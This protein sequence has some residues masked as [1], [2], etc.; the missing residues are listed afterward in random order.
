MNIRKSEMITIATV[1]LTFVVSACLYPEMPE[2]MATHW[3]PRGAVDGYMS[4]SL[5][6][7]LMPVIIAVIYGI[8]E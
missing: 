5:A 1:L 2:K 4:K 8:S 7:F 6:V 3:N